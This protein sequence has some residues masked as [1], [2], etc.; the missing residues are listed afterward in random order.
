M[1]S[2][3][4]AEASKKRYPHTRRETVLFLEVSDSRVAVEASNNKMSAYLVDYHHAA[5]WLRDKVSRAPRACGAS[6]DWHLAGSRV[7]EICDN[8]FNKTIPL[9]QRRQFSQTPPNLA[10]SL[11]IE[12]PD[13]GWIRAAI[14]NIDRE[15][16]EA[17][18][19]PALRASYSRT[20]AA[21]LF[22]LAV[23]ENDEPIKPH[24]EETS[25]SGRN[26]LYI[27]CQRG[28]MTAK[29]LRHRT[30][31]GASSRLYLSTKGLAFINGVTDSLT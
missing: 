18:A 12:A 10:D 25:F 23:A 30:R 31:L 22:K 17:Y 15:L 9:L 1:L 19:E 3:V 29:P 2:A 14:S 8:L 24:E 16:Q 4:K 5:L 26:A 28:W 20:I 7:Q 27:A 11:L 13:K 21:A 6:F